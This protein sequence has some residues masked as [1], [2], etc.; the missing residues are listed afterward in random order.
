MLLPIYHY[1]LSLVAV[2]LKVLA[3]ILL[4]GLLPLLLYTAA[5]IHIQVCLCLLYSHAAIVAWYMALSL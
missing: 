5:E 3:A 2:V 4:N 1:K